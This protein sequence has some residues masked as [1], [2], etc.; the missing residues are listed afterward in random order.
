MK[1]K[2]PEFNI[3]VSILTLPDVAFVFFLDVLT[4]LICSTKL[5]PT[6]D[7]KEQKELATELFDHIIL[8]NSNVRT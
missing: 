8:V 1:L 4:S 5:F 6:K 2:L 7:N 3:V